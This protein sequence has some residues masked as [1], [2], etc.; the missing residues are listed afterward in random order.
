MKTTAAHF[1]IFKAAVAA[2]IERL[3]L[4]DW[5]VRL[6]HDDAPNALAVVRCDVANRMASVTL[7]R[8]WGTDPITKEMLI[9]TAVHEMLHVVLA[10]LMDMGCSR[11][12]TKDAFDGAEHA[13]IRRLEKLL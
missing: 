10:E 13:V 1:K 9:R 2:A 5:D 3:G 6:Q 12:A 11:G 8:D 4:T 7:A